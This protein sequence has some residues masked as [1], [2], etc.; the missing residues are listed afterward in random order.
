MVEVKQLLEY[1]EKVRHRYFEALTKLPWEE[2]VENREASFNSLRNIFIHTLG[3][4]DYWLDFL[5]NQKSPYKEFDEYQ[6]FQDVRDRMKYIEK[7]MRDYLNSLPIG[8]LEKKYTVTNDAKKTVEV[9]AEDI[10]IHVFEEEV[11]HRGEFIALLWQ[12]GIEP[13]LMGWKEL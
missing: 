12:M 6:T 5:Q 10:L 3:A 11:H 9:T 8:G 13:P 4:I 2:F 7:R 1:N